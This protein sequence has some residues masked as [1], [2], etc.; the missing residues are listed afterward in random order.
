M[1]FIDVKYTTPTIDGKVQ[2]IMAKGLPVITSDPET[3][4]GNLALVSAITYQ[5]ELPQNT[6]FGVLPK[7][8]TQSMATNIEISRASKSLISQKI[9][10]DTLG[11]ID[12]NDGLPEY[13]KDID[14]ITTITGGTTNG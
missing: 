3:I 4:V 11:S 13:T 1:I 7:D 9:D 10:R 8:K 14:I 2:I 5:G 12:S 6:D